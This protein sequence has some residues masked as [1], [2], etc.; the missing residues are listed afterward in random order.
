MPCNKPYAVKSTNS[1]MSGSVVPKN[2]KYGGSY[3]D[4]GMIKSYEKGGIIE[5]PMP[6]SSMSKGPSRR[7][8]PAKVRAQREMMMREVEG[9]EMTEKTQEGYRK[10]YGKK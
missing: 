3:K 8:G 6:A 4:G 9:N 5:R 2:L 10:F 7:L 1:K